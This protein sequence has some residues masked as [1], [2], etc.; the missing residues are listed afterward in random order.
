MRGSASVSG[1]PLG[2]KTVL[3]TGLKHANR[4]PYEATR[5]SDQQM[6]KR[7]QSGSPWGA[8]DIST[9]DAAGLSGLGPCVG[10]TQSKHSRLRDTS[11][12]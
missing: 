10:V 7:S 11:C 6:G 9:C 2:P 3:Q 4:H 5:D 8:G 12:L 1:V